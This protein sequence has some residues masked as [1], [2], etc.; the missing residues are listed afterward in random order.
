[1]NLLVKPSYTNWT[2]LWESRREKQFQTQK[3]ESEVAQLCP[4]LCNPMDCNVPGSSFQGI[5]QARI[6]EWV[7][8]SF[9]KRSSQPRDWTRVSRIVGRCFT[10]WAT[11]E[12]PRQKP[13]TPLI[14]FCF[15]LAT[16]CSMW[17]LSSPT[18]DATIP[19][20]LERG[21]LTSGPPGKSQP[22]LFFNASK[23]ESL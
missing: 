17:D 13:E 6:L 19:P 15:V 10:I 4:T 1:M 7:A 16:S 8:I 9:S 20:A 14:L 2:F 21:F 18:R 11:R 22:H 23:F 5:F 3:P 12:V